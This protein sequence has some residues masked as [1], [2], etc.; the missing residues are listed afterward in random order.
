MNVKGP[1]GRSGKHISSA[2]APG[3]RN[4]GFIMKHLGEGPGR[5]GAG[6]RARAGGPCAS[7]DSHRTFVP[8][9]REMKTP[10]TRMNETGSA[11]L[12]VGERAPPAFALP[13]SHWSV[14]S[15]L[16]FTQ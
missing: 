2:E 10:F 12:G 14:R 13:S 9:G 5:E 1:R 16:L 8:F 15:S 7:N 11:L 3:R 4:P 6:G